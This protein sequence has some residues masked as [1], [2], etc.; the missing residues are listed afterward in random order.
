MMGKIVEA[1]ERTGVPEVS[2]PA[3]GTSALHAYA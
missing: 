2:A 1:W 3:V